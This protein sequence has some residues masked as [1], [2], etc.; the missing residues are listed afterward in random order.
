MTPEQ[1]V[2]VDLLANLAA[3]LPHS[4]EMEIE[5]CNGGRRARRRPRRVDPDSAWLSVGQTAEMLGGVSDKLIYKL[6]HRGE[7][8]GVKV[9]GAVRIRKESAAG[10]LDSHSNEKTPQEEPAELMPV[11]RRRRQRGDADFTDFYLRE[12]DRIERRIR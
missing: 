10:Y 2:L 11:P 9:A 3:S 6:Y 5:L 1:H 4:S 12:M 8:L 7:L